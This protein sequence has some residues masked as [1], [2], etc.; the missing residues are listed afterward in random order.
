VIALCETPLGIA[1]SKA[2]AECS[3]TIAVM[4]GAEDLIAA[5]GGSASRFEDGTFRDV[6][7]FARAQV[8]LA[9]A[10]YGVGALDAVFTDF[11]DIEGQRREAIDAAAMGFMATACIHPSQVDVVREAYR[12]SASQLQWAK[13]LLEMAMKHSGVFR[14]GNQMVDE[15]VLA[16]ARQLLRRAGE[17]EF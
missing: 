8:L 10:Q 16:Q 7:R 13:D 12:P 17:G 2:I 5:I 3:N 15:P 6:A 11:A 4:W 1:E 9:A 14:M